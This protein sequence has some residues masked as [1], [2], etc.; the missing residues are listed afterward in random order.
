MKAKLSLT[1]L[2]LPGL[3]TYP[4]PEHTIK[5]QQGILTIVDP[6]RKT[7]QVYIVS[8]NKVISFTEIRHNLGEVVQN[9]VIYSPSLTHSCTNDES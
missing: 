8:S 1:L 6:Q 2:H 3:S 9:H 4:L 7:G 5:L